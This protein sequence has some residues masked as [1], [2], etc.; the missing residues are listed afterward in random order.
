[1]GTFDAC[2]RMSPDTLE[3]S[4]TNL[5]IHIA[6]LSS[7]QEE[8]NG[9]LKEFLEKFNKEQEKIA[10]ETKQARMEMFHLRKSINGGP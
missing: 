8:Q 10:E 3:K 7:R 6:M 5:N 9:I 1:M 4:L 2:C